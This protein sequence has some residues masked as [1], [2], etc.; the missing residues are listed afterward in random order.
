MRA[1]T[2]ER[3][4]LLN[5]PDLSIDASGAGTNN[6]ALG[7][8]RQIRRGPVELFKIDFPALS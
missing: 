2:R 3:A 4:F 7:T 8:D 6:I 5:W 1:V